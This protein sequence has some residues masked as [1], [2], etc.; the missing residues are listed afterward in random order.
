MWYLLVMAFAVSPN[1]T[2]PTGSIQFKFSSHEQC[3][4]ER[5]KILTGTKLTD[6]RIS[7]VCTF[8]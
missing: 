3:L 5:D 6:H 4:T 7:A 8:R 2:Q 1:V